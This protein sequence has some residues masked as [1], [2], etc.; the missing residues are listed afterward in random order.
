[1]ANR[2]FA[3]NMNLLL[4][5]KVKE[6]AGVLCTVS[7]SSLKFYSKCIKHAFCKASWCTNAIIRL[8]KLSRT[9]KDDFFASCFI[10]MFVYGVCVWYICVKCKY[11]IYMHG[12]CVFM[13]L[14]ACMWK[15]VDNSECWSLLAIQFVYC[16]ICQASRPMRLQRVS[17]LHLP[18][19][20]CRCW[21]YWHLSAL[22]SLD[23]PMILGIVKLV[24]SHLPSS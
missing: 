19:S 6:W 9:K 4:E 3:R 16:F 22:L 11:I 7:F 23:F 13:W 10:C 12:M 21:E 2:V 24:S 14:W 1:M 5:E 8:R 20:L 17:S 18:F 15:S